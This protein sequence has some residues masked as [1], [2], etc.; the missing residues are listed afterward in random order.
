MAI[1][2]FFTCKN[3]VSDICSSICQEIIF[4]KI[5]AGTFKGLKVER[6]KGLKVGSF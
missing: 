3:A 4:V 2:P 5:R 6:F 1:H